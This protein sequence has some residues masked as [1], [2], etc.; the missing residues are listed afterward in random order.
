MT[1]KRPSRGGLEPELLSSNLEARVQSPAEDVCLLAEKLRS[2]PL[3][4]IRL[5]AGFSGNRQMSETNF[6]SIS[7]GEK[8]H[9]K[10]LFNINEFIIFQA[11]SRHLI[12]YKE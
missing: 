1:F 11:I 4:L 12:V 2:V 5:V 7:L 8:S 3:P 6:F 9:E 10:I